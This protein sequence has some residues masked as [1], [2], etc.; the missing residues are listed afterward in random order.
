MK[1]TLSDCMTVAVSSQSRWLLA[2]ADISLSVPIPSSWTERV[3]GYEREVLPQVVSQL[4]SRLWWHGEEEGCMAS[5]APL[6]APSLLP[7]AP[8]FLRWLVFISPRPVDCTVLATLAARTFVV[9]VRCPP[10]SVCPRL[11]LRFHRSRLPQAGCAGFSVTGIG[12]CRCMVAFAPCRLS[13]CALALYPAGFAVLSRRGICETDSIFAS[14]IP[15]A[16]KFVH[17]SE[18][19]PGVMMF[20]WTFSC[21]LCPHPGRKVCQRFHTTEILFL[22]HLKLRELACLVQ[23][24]VRCWL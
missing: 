4:W 19:V 2:E 16:L 17:A 8:G 18:I 13:V 9:R 14:S 22:K 21:Y 3:S 12:V 10:P 24:E 23:S 15:T 11:C 1:P 7:P 20:D 5:F 6:D